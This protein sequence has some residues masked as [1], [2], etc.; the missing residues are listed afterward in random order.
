MPAFLHVPNDVVFDELGNDP[1]L[2]LGQLMHGP[3]MDGRVPVDIKGDGEYQDDARNKDDLKNQ[4]SRSEG[5]THAQVSVLF[6]KKV[7][8]DVDTPDGNHTDPDRP[9][10][11]SRRSERR[12]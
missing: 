11:Q 6:F 9:I 10:G 4:G 5:E 7:N 12:T 2:L 3:S 8:N 1:C